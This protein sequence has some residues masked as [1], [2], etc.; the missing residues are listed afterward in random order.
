ME[1]ADRADLG[2]RAVSCGPGLLP[3]GG[4][5]VAEDVGVTGLTRKSAEP[6]GVHAEVG[7]VDVLVS[8]I[9]DA[10]ADLLLTEFIRGSGDLPDVPPPHREEANGLLFRE[11][12]TGEQIAK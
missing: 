12:V 4:F 9:G 1:A 11:P 7:D 10:I 3:D 2:Y 5:V 6:A 8:D